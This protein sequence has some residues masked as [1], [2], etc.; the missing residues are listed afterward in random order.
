ME[1]KSP[2]PTGA[3]NRTLDLVGFGVLLCSMLISDI[4]G[5][6]TPNNIG[7]QPKEIECVD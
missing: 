5:M 7:L 4:E 1:F 6:F 2:K 3:R